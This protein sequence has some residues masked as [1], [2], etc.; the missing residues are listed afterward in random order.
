[1]KEI[2]CLTYEGAK[3]LLNLHERRYCFEIFGYD[4]IIDS[5]FEVWLIEANTNPCIYILLLLFI[6]F[7]IFYS[8]FHYY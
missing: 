3:P 7:L 5:S 8:F 6:T 2:I 1:M 4:F